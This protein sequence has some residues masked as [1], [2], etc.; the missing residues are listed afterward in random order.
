MR[1]RR[2]LL[3]FVVFVGA[4]SEACSDTPHEAE[5]LG[6][7]VE[8]G[9]G[10]RWSST[11]DSGRLCDGG[12]QRWVGYRMHDGAP[13]DYDEAFALMQTEPRSVLL[14]SQLDCSDGTGAIS[15]AWNPDD[16]DRWII[17]GGSG[18]YSGWTGGGSVED[19]DGQGGGPKTLSGEISSG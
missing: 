7:V 15:I 13:A 14:E 6:I 2:A 8:V 16:G 3:A 5:T 12:S 10:Q 11:S 18:A 1:I 4:A 9:G 17:V 19:E